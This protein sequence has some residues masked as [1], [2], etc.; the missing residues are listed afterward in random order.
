MRIIK[1]L[2]VLL[3][4]TL[5]VSLFFPW[6]GVESKGVEIGGFHSKGTS[7]YG[8]PGLFHIVLAGIFIVFLFIDKVWSKRIAYFF[9][10]LNVAWAIRNFSIISACSGGICPEKFPAV[11]VLLFG[12]LLMFLLSLFIDYGRKIE[13]TE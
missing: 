10:A 9:G 12:S 1:I 3:W 4:I 11:Y 2:V 7:V 13:V 5:M 6:V 8:K